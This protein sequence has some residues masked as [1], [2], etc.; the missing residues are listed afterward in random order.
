MV[1]CHGHHAHYRMQIEMLR[2]RDTLAHGEKLAYVSFVFNSA[3][4]DLPNFSV[5]AAALPLG[6]S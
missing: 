4:D 2:L 6:L 3:Y 5:S 1:P